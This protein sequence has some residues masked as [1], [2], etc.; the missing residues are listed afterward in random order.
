MDYR[1]PRIR[2]KAFY[3]RLEEAGPRAAAA[4]G[5]SAIAGHLH[6]GRGAQSAFRLMKD[7]PAGEHWGG[8]RAKPR[9]EWFRKQT[10]LNNLAQRRSGA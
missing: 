8:M 9:R 2:K 1:E 7:V 10:A 5:Q 3:P 6:I 4:G